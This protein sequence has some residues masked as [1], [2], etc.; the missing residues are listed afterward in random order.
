MSRSGHPRRV[1][2]PGWLPSTM[3]LHGLRPRTR[4]RTRGLALVRRLS[5]RAHSWS[6]IRCSRRTGPASTH[7]WTGRSGNDEDERSACSQAVRTVLDPDG[8]SRRGGMHRLRRRHAPGNGPG[9]PRGT[10]PVPAPV[11]MR[12]RTRGRRPGA[13]AGMSASGRRGSDDRHSPARSQGVSSLRLVGDVVIARGTGS[14]AGLA[15]G[16]GSC[17]SPRTRREPPPAPPQ[18]PHLP[19]RCLR[20]RSSPSAS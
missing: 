13:P 3:V 15:P 19:G 6:P 14:L 5:G 11:R 20:S 1:R 8:D 16:A 12:S 7:P 9:S 18:P 4:R 17:A 2:R 10:F